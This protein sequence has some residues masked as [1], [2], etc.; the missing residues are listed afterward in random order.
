MGHLPTPRAIVLKAFLAAAITGGGKEPCLAGQPAVRSAGLR[1]RV[2]VGGSPWAVLAAALEWQAGGGGAKRLR[3]PRIPGGGLGP[4]RLD[5][6]VAYRSGEEQQRGREEQRAGPQRGT[7]AEASADRAEGWTT[8]P[9][10]EAARDA[11]DREHR[12]P[13]G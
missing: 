11:G 5:P 4:L 3:G 7:D 1:R 10:A 6:V 12:G 2:L 9:L 8:H 13:H